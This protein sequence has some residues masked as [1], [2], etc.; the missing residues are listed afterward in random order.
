M[1]QLCEPVAG[2]QLACTLALGRHPTLVGVGQLPKQD[3]IWAIAQGCTYLT[4]G[5]DTCVTLE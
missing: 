1:Q 4:L 3:L 2:I 5:Y